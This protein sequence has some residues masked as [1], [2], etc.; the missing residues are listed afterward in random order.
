MAV[1]AIAIA[2]VALVAYGVF[3]TPPPRGFD[4]ALAAG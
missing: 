2:L 4:A 3:N 1:L